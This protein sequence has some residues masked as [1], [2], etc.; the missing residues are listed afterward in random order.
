[1]RSPTRRANGLRV[2]CSTAALAAVAATVAGCGAGPGTITVGDAAP[3]LLPS[4]VEA[5]PVDVVTAGPGSVAV[6]LARRSYDVGVRI[7][8]NRAS[9]PNR[10]T[11]TL[12]RAGATVVGAHADVTAAMT[13]MDMGVATY[14][15]RGT[16]AYRATAPAW[17]MPGVWRLLVTVTPPHGTPIRL[18]LDDRLRS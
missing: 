4:T 16:T 18:T 13:A 14:A 15:L 3:P 5:T 6:H 9:T 1:M 12:R 17:V 10:I 2:A 11:V 7:V 8:P